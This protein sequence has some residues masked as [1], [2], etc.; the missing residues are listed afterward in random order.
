ML[1][2]EYSDI[3]DDVI[4]LRLG[5]TDQLLNALLSNAKVALQLSI[6]EGFEI[7]V[8][9]AIHKGVPIIASK[10]GGIPLQFEHGFSGFVV[11]P[12]NHDRVAEY[13]DFLFSYEGIYA[14]VS[15][16]AKTYVSD[17][18][19]TVGNALCWMY[20][21]DV[22]TKG[23]WVRPKGKW[24]YDMAREGAGQEFDEGEVRLP[25]E[26]KLRTA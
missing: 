11:E 15:K 26:D 10:A 12:G 1:E 5:P 16:H 4:A 2:H 22:M 6:R 7:K 21:A 19:G 13:L 9:E 17:E 3:A 24:I 18:L 20:L 23:E 14:S 8:S 25:R